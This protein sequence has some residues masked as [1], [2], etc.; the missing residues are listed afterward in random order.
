MK[1]DVVNKYFMEKFPQENASD[2]DN[3][4]LGFVI[5]DESRTLTGILLALDLTTETLEEAIKLN[6]NYIVTH[7]PFLYYPTHKILL[8]TEKGSIVNLMM[9]KDINLYSMHTNLDVGEGGVNDSLCKLLGINEVSGEV[10]KDKFLRFGKIKPMK[11][12][13]FAKLCVEK[14]HVSGCKIS[15]NE[16]KLIETVGIVG[17]GSGSEG[18]ILEALHANVDCYIGGEMR[19]S[20]AQMAKYNNL[21]LIE[22]N[23][24]IEKNVFP[25]IKEMLE[26][27]LRVDCPVFVSSIDTDPLHYYSVLDLE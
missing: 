10:A 7:H 14:L 24:G 23:H 6:C 1:I 3:G 25:F 27:D 5:G 12:K 17:G 20:A 11:L 13:N 16:D 8:N 2:F 4:K 19:L 18:M 15:G 26:N 9:K 21:N 22:L